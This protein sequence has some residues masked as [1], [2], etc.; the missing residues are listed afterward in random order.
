MA[1]RI[2]LA[3]SPSNSSKGH[4][5]GQSSAGYVPHGGPVIDLQGGILE[6]FVEAQQRSEYF[7]EY[8]DR[9]AFDFQYGTGGSSYRCEVCHSQS[10]TH[11]CVLLDKKPPEDF[12]CWEEPQ[13]VLTLRAERARGTRREY[14]RQSRPTP[15]LEKWRPGPRCRMCGA[16]AP[17]HRCINTEKSL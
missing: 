9:N 4:C 5:V 10:E 12:A 7:C 2:S 16:Q 8:K 17:Q 6:L 11:R 15:L 1:F 3:G 13:H 14:Y